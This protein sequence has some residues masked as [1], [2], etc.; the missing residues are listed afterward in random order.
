M[1]LF[2]DLLAK[3]RSNRYEPITYEYLL[4][5]PPKEPEWLVDTLFPAGTVNVLAGDGGVGKS[6][7]ALHLSLCVATGYKFLGIFPVRQG[8]VLLIDE[9]NLNVLIWQRLKKLAAGMKLAFQP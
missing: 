3:L 7:L 9:E 2:T 1:N 8:K 5:N 4:A 6:W